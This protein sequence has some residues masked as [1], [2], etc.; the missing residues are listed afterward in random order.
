MEKS[1]FCPH[2]CPAYPQAKRDFSLD[3]LRKTPL[4]HRPQAS[5]AGT[6][7]KVARDCG[8]RIAGCGMAEN[9]VENVSVVCGLAA[10]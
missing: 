8:M 4:S 10:C 7:K 9:N 2:A 1:S 5:E 6:E 3:F